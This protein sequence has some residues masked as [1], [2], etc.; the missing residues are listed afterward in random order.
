MKKHLSILFLFILSSISVVSQQLSDENFVYSE[1][2]QKA[3]QSN[4]YNLLPKTDI[5]KNII[6]FDGLGRPKQTI[7]INKGPNKLNTNLLDWKNNWALGNSVISFFTQNGGLTENIRIN[8]QNPFGKI[9]R[10]WRCIND[11]ASDADGGWNTSLIPVDKTQSYQYAVWVKRTG[12]QNGTTYHGTQNVVN[13]DGSANSNP[14][15]W[16]GNLPALDTWYLMVGM[17]H[18]ATYAGGYSG[19]SGV[20]DMAGNKVLNGTDFKWSS[21]TIDAYFRSYLYY[22]TDLGVSQYFYNPLLQKIDGNQASIS[23]IIKGFESSDIITHIGYDNYGRQS[24]D[25]LPY[26]ISS[27]GGLIQTN[28]VANILNYY[29]TAKYE[30]TLNPFSEKSFEVSPLNRIIKQASPG[31]NWKTQST[32]GHEIKFNYWTNTSE[33]VKQFI[34]VSTDRLSDLGL[35]ETSITQT[36]TYGV[37]QLYKTITKDENWLSGLDKT[38]EEFK[39]KDGNLVLK[40]TYNNQDPHDTYYVYDQYGN[41]C[42][43]LPPLA[44]GAFDDTTLNLLCY[45]YKYDYRNR[46]VEKKLPGKEWEYIIYDKLDRP[47]LIQDSN[48]RLLNKWLLT[49]YDALNRPVYTGEY[50]STL[51]RKAVQDLATGSIAATSEQL[52]GATIIGDM[53]AYYSNT[54]FPNNNF[55]LNTINY[56]DSYNFDLIGPSPS[57]VISY[58]LVP[59]SSVKGLPTGGKVRVLGTTKWITNIIYYDTK[60]RPIYSYNYND[61]LEITNALKSKL[62]FTGQ[63]TETTSTHTKATVTTTVI[64]QFVYD[65]MGRFLTQKQ[66]INSQPEEVIAFNCYDDLGQLVNK[67]VGGKTNQNRLQNVDYTYNVRGWL[68]TIND[69]NVIGTDLFAF[70]INY[71]L[72]SVGTALYNGNISQTFWRTANTDSSVRNYNYSYDALNRITFAADNLGFY[73]E[74]PTYDKNGNIKTLFRN[75]N[76]IPG[77]ATFGTIDNLTYTY[78]SGNRLQKVEDNAANNEGFK[79]GSNT[80]TEYT[81]DA[82]GN[83]KTDANKGITAITYNYLNLPVQITLTGGSNINYVYDAIGVK[84]RKVVGTIT[85]DYSNGYQYENDVLQYF[86]QPEGYVAHSAGVFSYIYQ[87]KD[88]LGNIRLSY[89]DANNDGTVYSSEIIE[90]SNYYPFGLKHSGYNGVTALGKG[91]STGQKY[92]YNGKEL[93]D[94]LG[95]NM[96]DYGARNYDPALGRW[97]NIDP[98]AEKV[99]NFS[100]YTYAV[101]N[102]IYFVDPDG[103]QI[104]ISLIYKKDKEGNEVRDKD[105]NRT[106][107]NINI[108]ITGKVINFSDNNVDMN[109]A[110]SD[111]TSSLEKS[112]SGNMDGVKVK[113]KANFS[114]AKSMNDVKDSDHLLV[115]ANSF[116]P[117]KDANGQFGDV[118]GASNFIGGRVAFVD[119]GYFSGWYDKYFGNQ[120]LRTSTHEFGHLFGLEHVMGGLMQQ[121]GEG[122]NLTSSQFGTILQNYDKKKLNYGTNSTIFGLPNT[123]IIGSDNVILTNTNGRAK[124]KS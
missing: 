52:Q 28:A 36:T 58:G 69:V 66:K 12:G 124:K 53:T 49:K 74:N 26:A 113:T 103:K 86:P 80:I 122:T 105:G 25:Y 92:K 90:E 45:R 35:Y 68:K 96:Y 37:G 116:K 21:T 87:Y 115:L 119:A 14:Y 85:T 88:H 76:T 70:K 54:A 112:F 117:Q 102:P 33:E 77:S 109:Q 40:R 93:Q 9:D 41:L 48:L 62:D 82:N 91:N 81:Y 65:H 72:P 55:N 1:T 16:Y 94:E 47:I 23:G 34:A 100:P 99:F 17:I 111:I 44:N 10:L 108:T 56:Y 46:L 51:N 78:D 29:N 71:D 106:L 95:L 120:G 60:G 15:F 20:Y 11:A 39:D 38:T 64:D 19:I 83:M 24:Q 75:G 123:G 18:P 8:G 63:V 22:S 3:V 79:N 107:T 5:Q 121:G 110:V 13:L 43:V 32:S 57:T 31:N 2:P 30:N 67:S 84:Q 61:Y 27:T 118:Y 114:I 104:D 7:G 97:M 73:N 6:Y 50:T 42:Y 89:G 59:V 101:N 4:S 98:L